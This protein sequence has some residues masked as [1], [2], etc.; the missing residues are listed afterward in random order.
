MG[1]HNDSSKLKRTR[2]LKYA[3]DASAQDQYDLDR[4]MPQAEYLPRQKEVFSSG[5]PPK[6]VH[7]YG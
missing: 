7:K 6:S 2:V 3:V 5:T 1:I 4:K